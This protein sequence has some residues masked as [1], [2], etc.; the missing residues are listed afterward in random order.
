M[1]L[2]NIDAKIFRCKIKFEDNKL[3]LIQLIA[4][5]AKSSNFDQKCLANLQN[6]ARALENTVS[7]KSCDAH[8]HKV[9]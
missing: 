9:E 8:L 2:Y 6:R 7:D 5:K 3:S 4:L 1:H